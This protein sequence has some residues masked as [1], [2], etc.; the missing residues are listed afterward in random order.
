MKNADREFEIGDILSFT[1][2]KILSRRGMSGLH[3]L[4]AHLAGLSLMT[5]ELGFYSDKLREEL[6]RQHPDLG[7]VKVPDVCDTQDLETWLSEAESRYGVKR[8]VSMASDFR[9]GNPLETF[10]AMQGRSSRH[11]NE[12][13]RDG[14]QGTIGAALGSEEDLN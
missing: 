8:K 1:T 4:G 10:I 13:P 12:K 3:V 6:L 11:G 2:G 7:A 9:T 14:I 5:H